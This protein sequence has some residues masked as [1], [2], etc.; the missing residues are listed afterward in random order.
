MY[1]ASRVDL[2]IY[3]WIQMAEDI[4]G[5]V[6]RCFTMKTV[7]EEIV[8]QINAD[9][10]RSMMSIRS[11]SANEQLSRDERKAILRLK[12]PNDVDVLEGHKGLARILHTDYKLDGNL[13]VELLSNT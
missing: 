7:Y 1:V 3:L 12:F 11:F 10:Y 2:M 4:V 8:E 13:G 5:V 9:H 6:I